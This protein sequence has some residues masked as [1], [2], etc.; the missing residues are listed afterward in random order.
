MKKPLIML[1]PQYED[2]SDRTSLRLAYADAVIG[3]G[4]IPFALSMKSG[5]GYIHELL[6]CADGLLLTGGD[7]VAPELYGEERT[8]ECGAVSVLRDSFEIKALQYAAERNMPVLGICR[9]IQVMNVAFGGTLYQDMKGHMQSE[10]KNKPSHF[11]TV[12]S[13]PL[14]KIYPRRARVNSFHHQ[15][16]K[17]T[18]KRLCACAVSDDGYTEAVYMPG[19]AFFIG[20]QW[21][22][23][24][25]TVADPYAALLFRKF[26]EA[27]AEYGKIR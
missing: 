8:G 21:H 22:P 23:E 3:A 24:H 9:G 10:N 16:V 26:T 17:R 27:A 12:V 4:G 7:D 15:A 18:A 14:S 13:S 11:V 25:M 20:V 19:K 1:T 6:D 2:G 5:D